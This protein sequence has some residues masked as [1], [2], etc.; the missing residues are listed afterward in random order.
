M[1]NNDLGAR[2]LEV[3]RFLGKSQRQI[4]EAVDVSLTSWQNYERG[5]NQ[6]GSEVLQAIRRLGV[7][8][9]WLLTG[10]GAM[11]P[12]EAP[13]APAG[14]QVALDR[15]LHG[16]VVDGIARIYKEERI[17]LPGVDLGRIAADMYA[18]LANAGLGSWDEKMAALRFALEQLRRTLRVAP[19]AGEASGKR[20]A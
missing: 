15:E 14:G 20:T 3:R 12:G 7:S 5:I 11:R 9:D 8:V 18:D 10:E 13:A 17:G 1:D 4:A 19:S 16:R 6:P 2:F